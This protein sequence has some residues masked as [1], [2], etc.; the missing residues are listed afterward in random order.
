MELA[1]RAKME[2]YMR[3]N[4]Q[5]LDLPPHG[6]A[7]DSM[8]DY[9]VDENGTFPTRPR[10]AVGALNLPNTQLLLLIRVINFFVIPVYLW[11]THICAITVLLYKRLSILF[12]RIANIS[13][14]SICRG[15]GTSGWWQHWGTR[16]SEYVYPDT[17]TPDYNSILVPNVDNVRMDFLIHTVA[18]Q[19][20]VSNEH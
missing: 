10:P 19:G 18:Q 14:N 9:R 3:G 1:D 5:D 15:H 12:T 16:V 11:L 4:C 13:L 20:K 2:H 8:F 7:D 17:G 6:G